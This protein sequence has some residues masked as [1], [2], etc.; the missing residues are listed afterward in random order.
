MA[1]AMFGA[2]CFWGVESTFS[3][4]D[5]VSR[6]AVGYA[7][8]TSE[9][10]S[11]EEVCGHGTG[12]AEVVHVEFDPEI[13]SY[14]A[15]LDSFWEAHDPTTLNRQ[16]PDRGTQYRSCVYTYGDEQLTI[17]ENSK[18]SAQSR[19]QDALSATTSGIFTNI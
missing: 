16:G 7:G 5:G 11:Y 12:H 15:L 18:A 13:V 19:F 6:T 9:N 14:E 8:G 4:I 10:P 17:A 3:K 1:E 2:G